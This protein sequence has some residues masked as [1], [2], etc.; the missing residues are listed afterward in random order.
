MQPYILHTAWGRNQH[1]IQ[2]EAPE[3]IVV[4]V[5]VQAS[6]SQRTLARAIAPLTAAAVASPSWFYLE[7]L[8][9]SWIAQ[10]IVDEGFHAYG[11]HGVEE[12]AACRAGFRCSA[13]DDGTGGVVH[14]GWHR[15]R[16]HR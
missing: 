6:C 13:A 1:I 9:L 11:P 5:A 15:R 4:E 16:L 8:S 7:S 10:S 2:L 3:W 12:V 14:G